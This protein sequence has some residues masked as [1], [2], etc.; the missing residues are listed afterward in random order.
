MGGLEKGLS[1]QEKEPCSHL[2]MISQ[3]WANGR[4]SPGHREQVVVQEREDS[5]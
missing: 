3:E 2:R 5:G 4:G 1:V